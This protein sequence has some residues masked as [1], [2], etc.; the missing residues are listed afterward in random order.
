LD[1]DTK[2]VL[3]EAERQGFQVRQTTRQHPMVY[4][5]GRF[6]AQFSGTPGDQRGLRNGIAALR[7]AGF[8][9]PPKRKETKL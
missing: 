5:D 4:R 1:K 6:V 2:K 3:D 8:Q 9:W 7:R